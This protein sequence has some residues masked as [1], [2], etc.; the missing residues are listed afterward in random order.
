MERHYCIDVFPRAFLKKA[1]ELD[2]STVKSWSPETATP[3]VYPTYFLT[4]C[5]GKNINQI[6]A[7]RKVIV[8]SRNCVGLAI[9]FSNE[10]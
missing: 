2:V 7:T 6:R 1:L 8:Q 10:Q 5:I 3:H 9:R 4:Q